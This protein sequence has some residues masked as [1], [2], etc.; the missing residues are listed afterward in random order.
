MIYGMIMLASFP[1]FSQVSE[2]PAVY[3]DPPPGPFALFDGFAPHWFLTGVEVL[4]AIAFSALIFGFFVRAASIAATVLMMIGY[5][6]TYSTGSV[7]HSIL[8]VVV[9]I[10]MCFFPWGPA[11]ASSV[12][13]RQ[14]TMRYLAMLIGLGFL[15]AAIPKAV[16]GWLFVGSQATQ[17]HLFRQVFLNGRDD[18]LAP[19][20]MT[21]DVPVFWE[22]LDWA[23]VLMEFGIVLCVMRWWSFRAAVSIAAIFH[24]SVLLILNIPFLTNVVTYAA[25]IPWGK[26]AAPSWVLRLEPPVWIKRSAPVFCLL[27]GVGG[28]G[29]SKTWTANN[30]VDPVLIAVGA[31]IGVVYLGWLI[32]TMID[33]KLARIRPSVNNDA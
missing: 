7:S 2:L 23:T 33:V 15:T 25:F 29:L 31:L 8:S 17:G 22:L 18:R 30:Y 11:S 27:V 5:G 12:Q 14:W 20:F 4:L 19:F 13:P 9:P 26:V 16:T 6:S 28:W 24:L 1:K 21:F 32:W 3:Y 10:V